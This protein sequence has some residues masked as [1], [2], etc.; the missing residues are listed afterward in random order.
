MSN[1]WVVVLSLS[2]LTIT[3]LACSFSESSQS[4]STS[5]SSPFASSSSS[6]PGAAERAYEDDVRDYTAASVTSGNDLRGFQADLG[7]L[8]TKHGITNWEENLATYV[9]IGEG[10]AKAKVSD[11][12]LA[13]YKRNLG[14][15][16]PKKMDAIQNGY[17]SAR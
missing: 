3:P 14:G 1:R 9:A 7:K 13:A 12:Q 4:I 17:D 11:A 6:S 15:S 10:L 5:V 16:D 8:A 2:V